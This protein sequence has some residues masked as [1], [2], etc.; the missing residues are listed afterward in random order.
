[1]TCKAGSCRFRF[2]IPA[3][4]SVLHLQSKKRKKAIRF[5]TLSTAEKPGGQLDNVVF[6]PLPARP[7]EF[8]GFQSGSPI[9]CGD[10]SA[11]KNP[12][13]RN[14]SGFCVCIRLDG[15]INKETWQIF[16][17]K[18]L[19]SLAPETMNIELSYITK[20]ERKEPVR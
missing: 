4:W 2:F 7:M 14:C 1:M 11:V 13:S 12:A 3:L 17:A 18:N 16:S 19:R 6:H 9:G 8:A 10:F 15:D 20:T 5:S